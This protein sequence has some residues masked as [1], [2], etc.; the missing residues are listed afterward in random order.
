[1]SRGGPWRD[2]NVGSICGLIHDEH[3]GAIHRRALAESNILIAGGCLDLNKDVATARVRSALWDVELV[4][5]I[6]IALL[7][8][9]CECS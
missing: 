5:N 6:A 3:V 2:G 1:M 8:E 9:L 7:R 4:A